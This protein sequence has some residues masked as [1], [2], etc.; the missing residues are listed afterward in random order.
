[1]RSYR[2]RRRKDRMVLRVEVG[3]AELE[4]LVKRGYLEASDRSNLSAIEWAG[5]T[6]LSDALGGWLRDV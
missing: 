1:M 6:F 2:R 5:T 4:E 3:H